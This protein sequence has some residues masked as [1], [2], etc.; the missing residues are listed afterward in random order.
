M[1]K[2][3]QSKVA[4]VTNPAVAADSQHKA[5]AVTGNKL[6]AVA[7]LESMMAEDAGAGQENVRTED[8]AIPFL[9]LLQSNNPQVKKSSPPEVRIEGA[10][11]GMIL[12]TV[13]KKLFK[14]VDVI[15]CFFTS[16]LIEWKDR[17]KNEGGGFVKMYP[18]P[19]DP[20]LQTAKP[21]SAE[22]PNLLVLP[23]TNW[24]VPTAQ[25]YVL[26]KDADGAWNRAI[27]AMTSS[28]LSG[29]RRWNSLM[30]MEK[31]IVNGQTKMPP[32]YSR[33]Y[34]LK[35]TPKAKG[36]ISWWVF[37]VEKVGNVE[38][39]EVYM[40]ARRFYEAVKSGTIQVTPPADMMSDEGGGPKQG[41]QQS[42]P[43]ERAAASAVL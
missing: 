33:I 21:H 15:P 4:D 24:I 27:V 14:D 11:E 3:D 29:S 2:T 23:N 10:E 8:L 19:N 17:D 43:E 28:K 6:P 13:T 32:T 30:S 37:D 22:K 38:D 25:H 20:I 34:K 31:I 40:E 26:F 1:A 12:N 35:T 39:P 5:P 18:D 41:P 7:S 42:T 36:D 9:G 16:V